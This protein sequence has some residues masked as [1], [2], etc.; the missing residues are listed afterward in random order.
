M[1]TQV[2]IVGAGPAGLTLGLLL[3]RQ[4]IDTVVLE[5]RDRSY[6]EG[7]VRA[8]VLEQNTI[9]LLH[10][11]GVGQRLEREGLQHHGIYLRRRGE[12][13]YVPMMELTG[14]AITVYGQQ[15]VVKDLI[16]ARIA[17]GLPLEFDVRD[18]TVHGV[19]G[20]QPRI[21]YRH[22]GEPREL[23]AATSRAVTASTVS[24][25]PRSP[26]GS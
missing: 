25:G 17:A 14:R 8:G 21:T 18:V 6:V 24:A 5:A 3:Q 1:R 7:R 26:P 20:P 4:G 2:G 9:D 11:A 22:G 19:D 12:T 13:H 23:T 10:A 15:E 16:A